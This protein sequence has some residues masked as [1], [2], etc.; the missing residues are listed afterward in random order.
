MNAFPLKTEKKA[1]MSTPNQYHCRSS[2]HY[3]KVRKGNKSHTFW[4]ERN[5]TVPIHRQHDLF[6]GKYRGIYQNK[7]TK[8]QTNNKTNFEL[9]GEFSKVTRYKVNTPKSITVL[10]LII[11]PTKMQYLDL[12]LTNYIQDRYVENYK[13]LIY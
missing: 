3:T 1:R 5:K 10:S 11:A 4:K 13:I 8:K 2:S 7:Q 12:N 9:T 6:M